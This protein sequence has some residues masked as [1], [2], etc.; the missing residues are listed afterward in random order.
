MYMNEGL[1]TGDIIL[2]SEFALSDEITAG[3]LH[4]IMMEQGGR[5]FS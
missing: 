4:D 3:E 1:D 2:Q 5:A